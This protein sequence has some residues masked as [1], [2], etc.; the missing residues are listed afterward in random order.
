MVS[1]VTTPVVSPATFQVF[2]DRIKVLLLSI[3]YPFAIKSYFERALMRRPDVDLVTVGPYTN[4]WI[5][6]MGG[7]T[8]DVKY[9]SPPTIPL[10]FPPNVGTVSYDLVRAQL[11]NSWKP[12]IV[13]T[14]D[15]GVC[16]SSKPH[17]GI[18]AHVATDPHVINYDYQL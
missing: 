13:L 15:A 2:T 17:E 9:A 4:T 16:W 5:P 14:I 12:D 7:M 11:P 10:P 1:A 8:L 6:W 3:H 18:I